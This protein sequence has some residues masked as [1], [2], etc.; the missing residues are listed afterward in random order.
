V[1][2]H[3]RALDYLDVVGGAVT[4]SIQEALSLFARHK[5][6]RLT[7]HEGDHLVE[8]IDEKRLKLDM[9]KNSCLHFL[10]NEALVAVVLL[11]APG[12]A[13]PREALL[14]DVLFLSRLFK[15][16]FVYPTANGFEHNLDTACNFLSEWGLVHRDDQGARLVP[17]A[18]ELASWLASTLDNF[19]E[20]YRFVLAQAQAGTL[21]GTSRD[22]VQ[23]ELLRSARREQVEGSLRRPE[24]SST[25]VF[26]N[27]IEW[28]VEAGF[29]Q[30]EAPHPLVAE[31]AADLA[32]LRERLER[33]RP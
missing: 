31:R 24:S 3:P 26:G 15:R 17:E 21:K 8:L 11:R 18:R 2:S 14:G 19:V 16:E 1:C 27:A 7:A 28:L 5:L 9:Y 4:E 22:A 20:G 10:L 25:S 23:R 13:L 6:L 29:V 33:F 30:R 32:A 12:Q